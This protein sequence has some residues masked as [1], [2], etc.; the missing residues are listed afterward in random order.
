MALTGILVASGEW[1][2]PSV[3]LI[4]F[5]CSWNLQAQDLIVP[6]FAQLTFIPI[7][8][9]AGDEVQRGADNSHWFSHHIFTLPLI[10]V[11]LWTQN[12]IAGNFCG[13]EQ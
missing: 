10:A 5:L 1:Q 11:A 2:L 4:M 6:S 8:C 12:I 7:K 9:Q 3:V 13:T